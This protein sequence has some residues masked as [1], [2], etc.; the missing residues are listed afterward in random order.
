MDLEAQAATTPRNTG[1]IRTFI[2]EI[3]ATFKES[4]FKGTLRRYGWKIV[5][6]FFAYYLI[7]DSILYIIIPWMIAKHFINQ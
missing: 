5:A 3:R 6:I 4:G 7:R 2:S 1:R